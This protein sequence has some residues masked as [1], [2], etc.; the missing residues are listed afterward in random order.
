MITEALS[1][2]DI[3]NP[4]L[5]RSLKRG[6]QFSPD[7]HGKRTKSCSSAGLE[8]M[9]FSHV[10]VS[11]PGL[12]TNMVDFIKNADLKSPDDLSKIILLMAESLTLIQNQ[13]AILI[14]QNKTLS[15]EVSVLKT[16][17]GDIRAPTLMSK[18]DEK[19]WARIVSKSIQAP[20]SQVAIMTAAKLANNSDV[21]KS[22][23]ILKNA[24]LTEKDMTDL[25]RCKLITDECK[26]NG[27]ISVFRLPQQKGPP[28]LKISMG[29]P[30]DAIKV[31]SR[32]Q[33][34]R[35][36]INF[37]QKGSVRPDLTKPE[38]IQYRESWKQA[39]IKNNQ[40]K[41]RIYT[42]RDL[43]VVKIQYKEDQVPWAWEVRE[44]KTNTSR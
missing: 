28:L 11:I 8:N 6:H 2:E 26:V 40:E 4:A 1:K 21:R 9:E 36:K 37:C 17:I 35:E 29:S 24:D 7:S 39:I 20:A 41:K 33:N 18:S 5:D 16:S 27:P 15:E 38:L 14:S 23:I 34:C 10:A 32:F 13:N 30:E 25:E 42:V 3:G 22:S 31:L 12:T 44:E 19:S 43:K